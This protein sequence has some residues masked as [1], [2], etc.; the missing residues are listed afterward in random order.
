MRPL[1]Q[2]RHAHLFINHHDKHHGGNYIRRWAHEINTDRWDA[3]VTTCFMIY[4]KNKTKQKQMWWNVSGHV[5]WSYCF[6]PRSKN[7]ASVFS[8]FWLSHIGHILL[9]QQLSLYLESDWF[10]IFK[11]NTYTDI[12]TCNNLVFQ[13]FSLFFLFQT[14]T[15]QTGSSN[16]CCMYLF[17]HLCFV[18]YSVC[19]ILHTRANKE[20]TERPEVDKPCNVNTHNVVKASHKKYIK[21]LKTHRNYKFIYL[22]YL[23]KLSVGL[24]L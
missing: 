6:W 21:K 3:A 8:P 2:A 5:M 13:N 12:W 17:A 11:T 7:M 10:R 23:P 14:Y 22:W 4:L 16:I 15:T 20:V 19:G 24:Q 9:I 18:H 1:S